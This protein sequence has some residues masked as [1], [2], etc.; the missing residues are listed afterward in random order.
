[1]S[2]LIHSRVATYIKALST[3]LYFAMAKETYGWTYHVYPPYYFQEPR[4]KTTQFNETRRHAVYIYSTSQIR[5]QL[6]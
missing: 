5:I 2:R 1:M 6:L 3:L 4:K